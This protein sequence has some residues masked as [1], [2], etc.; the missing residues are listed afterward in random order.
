MPLLTVPNGVDCR[1]VLEVTWLVGVVGLAK[2]SAG[3]LVNVMSLVASGGQMAERA[4]NWYLGSWDWPVVMSPVPGRVQDTAAADAEAVNN[5]AIIKAAKLNDAI[6][7][8]FFA[9]V[10]MVVSPWYSW[11]KHKD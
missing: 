7:L 4:T 8:N 11:V 1:A 10:S 2:R 3:A 9:N 6:H 5:A